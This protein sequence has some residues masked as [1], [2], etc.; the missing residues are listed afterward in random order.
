MTK[1]FIVNIY[2][3]FVLNVGWVEAPIIVGA[4][5]SIVYAIMGLIANGGSRKYKG[6]EVAQS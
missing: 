6:V 5:G 4:A 1:I 2:L 3:V